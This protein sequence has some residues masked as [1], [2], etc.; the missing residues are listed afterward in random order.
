MKKRTTSTSVGV[1]AAAGAILLTVTAF[2]SSINL[3]I[4]ILIS[5]F[6]GVVQLS[7]IVV[8]WFVIIRRDY[9]GI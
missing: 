6:Y 2:S 1:I 5:V 9:E 3:T 7:L 8:P 4:A